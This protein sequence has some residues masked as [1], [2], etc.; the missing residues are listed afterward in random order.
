MSKALNIA[1]NAQQKLLAFESQCSSFDAERKS[2]E[3]Q[4][5]DIEEKLTAEMEKSKQLSE[6]VA[7]K[8]MELNEVSFF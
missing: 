6:I 8:E 1:H 2:L 4:V 3:N 7:Q 5:R